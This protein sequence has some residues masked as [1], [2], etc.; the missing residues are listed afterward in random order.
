[1]MFCFD[2]NVFCIED[3]CDIMRVNII[4]IKCYKVCLFFWIVY[5]YVVKL[6]EIVKCIGSKF[7]F[8]L[9][10]FVEIDFFKKINCGF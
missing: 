2:C 1:M 6:F 5:C 8:M 7:M 10:N 4:K 3:S 9:G